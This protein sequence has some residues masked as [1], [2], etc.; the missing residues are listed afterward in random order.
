MVDLATAASLLNIAE[1]I[2]ALIRWALRKLDT[3]TERTMSQHKWDFEVRPIGFTID[4]TQQLAF[5]EVRFY[6]I[7][8]LTRPLILAEVKVAFLHL[9]AGPILEHVPLVQ[10]DFH[11]G[12]KTTELVTC[13]RNLMDEEVRALLGQRS[14]L[15]TASF[16]LVAK[17]RYKQ[18]EYRYGPVASLGIEGWVDN[19]SV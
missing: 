14:G 16:A 10:E 13:R 7:N 15:H 8:Y 12:A 11:I 2:T 1:K 19:A 4:L 9:S 17:A 5:V 3:P 18:R 6:L